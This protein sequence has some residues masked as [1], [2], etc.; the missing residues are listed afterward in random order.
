MPDEIFAN[1]R[2]ASLYDTFDGLRDDLGHYVAL[3]DELGAQ[4][5]LDIGCGTGVLACLL[6]DRGIEVHGVDPAQAMLEVARGRPGAERVTWR[7]GTT[8]DLPALA[9][10]AAIMTG[11]VAQVFVTDEEWVTTLRD[12][13][14]A[15][16]PGGHLV[17]ETRDPAKR[18]WEGWT[19][20]TS[21]QRR[22]VD[23]VGT[24]ETWNQ[25][26]DE[27]PLTITFESWICF[28]ET[29]E[30]LRSES[31]LRFRSRAE[32]DAALDQAGFEVVDVRDA[33]DRPGRE[34]VYVAR[35]R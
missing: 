28:V 3:L 6:A 19:E 33:P 18:A 7:H 13:H 27:S 14:A 11:N 21:K 34:F 12:A 31:T 2:L 24:V 29:G 10:D 32:L 4:S 16:R 26:I 20:A 1:P 8:S 25:V 17:F 9:M 15:L 23:G 22:T 30:R 5:V 35:R